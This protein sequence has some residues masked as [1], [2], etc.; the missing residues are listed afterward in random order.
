MPG[1]SQ[2]SRPVK[3]LNANWNP[4][5]AD[6]AGAFEIMLITDD[7]QRHVAPASPAEVTALVAL[8][9]AGTVMV[10]DPEDSTLIV[11]NVVGTMPW[12]TSIATHG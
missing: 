12:T 11:A 4:S 3:I 2:N 10:W 9:Q 8:S 7:D 5:S 1:A 6:G